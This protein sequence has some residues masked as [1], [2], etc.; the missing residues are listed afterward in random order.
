M[1]QHYLHCGVIVKNSIF[2][3]LVSVFI[4]M[5]CSRIFAQDFTESGKVR[6][7]INTINLSFDQ[8][9]L[10]VKR[11]LNYTVSSDCVPKNYQ[12]G[13]YT[14]IDVDAFFRRILKG[15]N[16]VT[17]I[18]DQKRIIRINCMGMQSATNA[19]ST[20]RAV[21]TG[22]NLDQEFLQDMQ[23]TRLEEIQ[24]QKFR[25]AQVEMQGSPATLIDSETGLPVEEAEQAMGL[26]DLP[27]SFQDNVNLS[28]E[29]SKKTL[30]IEKEI[31]GKLKESEIVTRKE[32]QTKKQEAVV[33]ID[34]QTGLTWEEAEQA[35]GL[36]K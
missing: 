16:V 22:T 29:R 18:D 1:N 13:I 24:N 11:Q 3:F 17:L 12:K 5:S 27:L 14:D 19:M 23:G 9:L 25:T 35:M 20:V 2:F 36:R 30:D 31:A 10:S 8:I 4:L 15:E 21:D 32:L 26:K 6:V 34:S 28:Q 7:S 33:L